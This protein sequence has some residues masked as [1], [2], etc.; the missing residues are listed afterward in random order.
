P[1]LAIGGNHDSPSRLNFANKM[2]QDRGLHLV[3]E[4]SAS[5]DH[6]VLNDEYGEVHFHLVPY[7]DP[8]QVR[9]L[10]DDETI[11]THND[12]YEAIVKGLKEKI[13]DGERHVFIGHAFVTPY[14]EEQENTSESERPLS[15]GGAEYVS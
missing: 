10:L 6:V 9:H 2:M 11:Q 8:S 14:G 1:V 5:M 12:A 15:I 4:L 7:A 3:G 13:N